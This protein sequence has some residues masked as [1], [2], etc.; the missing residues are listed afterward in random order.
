VDFSIYSISGRENMKKIIQEN[1]VVYMA[2]LTS[3]DDEQAAEQA[4]IKGQKE[5]KQRQQELKLAKEQA[6]KEGQKE[7]RAQERNKGNGGGGSGIKIL[8]G[9]I[10]II[11]LVFI[12]AV[13]TL[14]VNVSNA[15]TTG[16]PM[17]FS[18]NYSVTFPEGQQITIGNT[19]ITVL[20]YQ[21]ELISNIDGDQQKLVEGQD[22]V[23]SQR[24]AVIT[25]LGSVTL[26]D[27]N[28]QID[29]KYKGQRD[30]L[31]YFDMV[32]HTSKQV[33]DILLR[34]LLPSSINASPM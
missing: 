26:M 33:P 29:L 11:I 1:L 25:T 23:I 13:L 18:S 30:N 15:G 19:H 6:R 17:P 4:R 20:T 8:L 3:R 21:N 5:E 28:F 24:R 27:I 2:D 31:A 16:V 14:N 32:I 34:Q 7:G 9:L 10:V 12:A 22:R